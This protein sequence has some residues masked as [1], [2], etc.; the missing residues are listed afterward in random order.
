[1]DDRAERMRKQWEKAIEAVT[2]FG[3]AVWRWA[4][5]F[6]PPPPGPIKCPYIE[7]PTGNYCKGDLPNEHPNADDEWMH[8]YSATSQPTKEA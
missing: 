1:M 8:N 5:A 2:A 7:L 6:N 4:K 3:E